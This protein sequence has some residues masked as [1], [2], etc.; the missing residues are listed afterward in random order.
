MGKR[1]SA[2]SATTAKKNANRAKKSVKT[3]PTDCVYDGQPYSQGSFLCQSGIRMECL[4]GQWRST[5]EN[6]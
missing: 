2:K 5:G 1:K 6:C 4:N 3:A